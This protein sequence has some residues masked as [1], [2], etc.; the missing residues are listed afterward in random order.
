MVKQPDVTQHD[1]SEIIGSGAFQATFNNE[2][3]N[4][5]GPVIIA[6]TGPASNP[7]FAAVFEPQNPIP[8]TRHGL[9]SGSSNDTNTIQGMNALAKQQGLILRWA[10]SYGDSSNQRFAAIWVPN[11]G[12]TMWNADGVAESGNDYQSR[13]NAQTSQWCRPAFVTLNPTPQYLSVFVDSEVVGGWHAR[14]GITAN[15]YQQEFNTWTAKGFFPVCVQAAAAPPI[16]HFPPIP[17][18]ATFAV[19]F[20]K[21][22]NTVRK[23]FTA[24]GPVANA[25][26]DNV[27][28]Q[29]MPAGGPVRHAS[30]AIVKGT[31]LVY[32]RGYTLAEP[33]W[34]IVQPTTRFRIASVSK[35][36]TALAIYQLIEAGKLKSDGSDK[37]QDILNL[38][39]PA[40]TAPTDP[41]FK[42][43]TIKNLLEHR[44]GLDQINYAY[45]INVQNAFKQAGK[46]VHL[47]ISPDKTDSYIASQTLNPA[48]SPPGTAQAYSNCGYYLLARVV[49]KL[50]GFPAFV[51]G[52]EAYQKYLFK[53]L[54]ITR[55]R[56]GRSLLANQFPDEARYQDQDL[57]LGPSQMSD[58]EPLVPDQYGADFQKEIDEGSGGLS[59]AAT[60]LARLVAILISQKDNPAMKRTTLTNMLSSGAALSAAGYGRAGYG[61]DYLS[62][63]PNNSLPIPIT[64]GQFYGQ[65]GGAIIATQSVL[66]FDGNLGFVMLWASLAPKP[67]STWYPDYR[68]VINIAKTVSWGSTDLF[69]QFG[70]PSL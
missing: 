18:N 46:T 70:M 14:H 11:P 66:Q 19:I 36:P 49:N 2:A 3:S 67:D 6:A 48:T 16:I 22:E 10:A 28:M 34:P 17:P 42:N 38:K 25:N 30:L 23:Q 27:I 26:I 61:F 55:I 13:F 68:A 4:G 45:G 8:L 21:S 7:L 52:I 53:P 51:S 65:K 44:N 12:K 43:I 1:Y 37:V 60:D 5:F 40:G 24:T 47:P 57:I 64:S 32:A 62:Q 35:T 69:P 63:G 50:R 9:L 29:A 54:S 31:H 15:E 56:Q 59:G 39:T 58:S 20:V 33:D 41:N